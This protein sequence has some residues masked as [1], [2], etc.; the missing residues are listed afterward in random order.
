[1]GLSNEEKVLEIFA[2]N[3]E[4]L[5]LKGGL[6]R[7]D[8]EIVA[9]TFGERLNS[10]TFVTHYEKAYPSVRGAYPMIN[11]LFARE[12]L[13]EYEFI[14]REDDLGSEGLRKAKMSY[15]PEFL[16]EKFTAVRN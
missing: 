8:G 7:I 1:M 9:F 13:G 14:N 16:V 6:L 11:M 12:S 4:K 3:Y 2:E 10:N 5:G 15:C